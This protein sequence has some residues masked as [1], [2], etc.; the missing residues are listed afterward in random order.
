M[1]SSFGFPIVIDNLVV[2]DLLDYYVLV[3]EEGNT[4]SSGEILDAKQFG[5][6]GHF[7][8]PAGDYFTIQYGNDKPSKID[9]KLYDILGNLVAFEV[10]H[11][12]IGY[13]EITF[14]ATKL[15]S[16]IYTYTLSNNLELITEHI[17][18]K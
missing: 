17:I 9:F 2:D 10:Y 18:I 7:P 8:N 11:S 13:N 3:I 16:G 5:H 1:K 14:D 6:L 12:T 4:S 15:I